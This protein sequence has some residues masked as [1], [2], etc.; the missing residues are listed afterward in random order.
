[1]KTRPIELLGWGPGVGKQSKSFH[2]F[3]RVPTGGAV[4]VDGAHFHTRADLE[5]FSPKGFHLIAAAYQHGRLC[6]SCSHI[7]GGG[8]AL[9][10]GVVR[11][12]K[13]FEGVVE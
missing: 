5:K 1:M 6:G 9:P 7:H 2:Y 12:L 10:A 3:A 11:A 13:L 4:S 8:K